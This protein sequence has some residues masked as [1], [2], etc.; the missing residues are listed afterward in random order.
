MRYLLQG[1]ILSLAVTPA[2]ILFGMAVSSLAHGRLKAEPNRPWIVFRDQP[3]KCVAV[4]SW[5]LVI[6]S[7]FAMA[8][9]CVASGLLR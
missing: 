4:V 6:A 5:Y 7:L 9:V 3:V 1:L 2:L 8:S